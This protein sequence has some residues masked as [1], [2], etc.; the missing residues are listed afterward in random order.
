MEIIKTPI[1]RLHDDTILMEFDFNNDNLSL[2]ENET[3]L[4]TTSVLKD[5]LKIIKYNDEF[6]GDDDFLKIDKTFR[7]SFDAIN[8]SDWNTLNI[9]NLNVLCGSE[10]EYGMIYLQFRYLALSELNN[11]NIKIENIVKPEY[12]GWTTLYVNNDGTNNI[13]SFTADYPTS[14]TYSMSI[15]YGTQGQIHYNQSINKYYY[16]NNGFWSSPYTIERNESSS[17]DVTFVPSFLGGVELNDFIIN[18]ASVTNYSPINDYELLSDIKF[19]TSLENS[20]FITSHKPKI[21]DHIYINPLLQGINIRGGE[22]IKINH[23]TRNINYSPLI[24]LKSIKLEASQN[25]ETVT[26]ISETEPLICLY[27][28]GDNIIFKPDMILKVFSLESYC[29]IVDGLELTNS[30]NDCLDIKFRYSS[31]T[32]WWDTSWIP[33]TDAN[34]K[35]VRPSRVKYFYIEFLFTRICENNKPIC[36]TDL[37][38]NGDFQNVSENYTKLNRFGIRPDCNYIETDEANEIVLNGWESD[39]CSNENLFNPYDLNRSVKL[40]E[41]ISSDISELFGHSV[42][43][44]KVEANEAGIDNILHEYQTYDIENKKTL[45]ITV[46]NNN[47]PEDEIVFNMFNLGMFNSFEVFVTKKEFHSKFGIDKRPA[48]KDYLFFCAINK[49]YEVEHAQSLRDYNNTSVYYKLTLSKK[50][51]DKNI[52]SDSEFGQEFLNLIKNNTMDNLFQ[53]MVNN[54]INKVVN[55]QITENLTEEVVEDFK[56]IFPTNI[57]VETDMLTKNEILDISKPNPVKTKVFATNIEYELVNGPNVITRNYYD[58]NNVINSN[59]VVY[60]NLDYNIKECDNRSFSVWFNI[61]EY[62]V[63]Q[64]YNLINNYNNTIADGYKI[65]F[66]D[67]RIE[68]LWNKQSFVFD[69]SLKLKK[70]YV[71]VVNFNQTM[72]LLDMYIYTRNNNGNCVTTDLDLVIHN[73]EELI[74]SSFSGD[75]ILNVQGSPMF[76]TNMRLFNEVIPTEK[77]NTILNQY[78]IKNTELLIVSD[79]VHKIVISPHWKF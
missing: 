74:P 13:F 1:T 51:N 10:F 24:N 41:K 52:N 61:T 19:G 17:G 46:N 14:G 67:G 76:W 27:N 35:C 8:Y 4:V 20:D 47:F 31:N 12:A 53:D 62:R 49:W 5:I 79:N 42:D 55:K 70:W 2:S 28:N 9:E 18:N 40:N 48:N 21:G 45:K 15:S 66:I 69:V 59:A 65:D 16:K 68:I 56:E 3:L 60:K 63:G 77:I 54:D 43:Y 22:T 75:F 11:Y 73:S 37:I 7:Y 78:L 30:C 57:I 33:L 38:I 50:D 26:S 36:I 58:F 44:Y 32:R 23:S 34:L 25:I 72:K 29:L 39:I 71:I 64:V 6:V